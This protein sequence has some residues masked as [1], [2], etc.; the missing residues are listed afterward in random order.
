MSVAN[1]GIIVRVRRHTID[2]PQLVV[3]VVRARDEILTRARRARGHDD[4][5]RAAAL[6]EA[7]DLIS[8]ALDRADT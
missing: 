6:R 8:A 2:R 3:E 4:T 1:S 7:A 5:H